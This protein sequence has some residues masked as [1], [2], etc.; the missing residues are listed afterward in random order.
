MKV[1]KTLIS[2]DGELFLQEIVSLKDKKR[3]L[4]YEDASGQLLGELSDSGFIFLH[5]NVKENIPFTKG[6]LRDW[7]ELFLDFLEEC[8]SMGH[9]YVFVIVPEDSDK[10]LKFTSLMGFEPWLKM[11]H[12]LRHVGTLV[13]RR[14]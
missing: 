1:E 11:L 7:Q 2:S 10:L 3:E 14:T 4:I 8:A 9:E 12:G 13:R 6:R 5:M